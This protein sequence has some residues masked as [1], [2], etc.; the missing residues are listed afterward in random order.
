MQFVIFHI[1]PCLFLNITLRYFLAE[2]S[3]KKQMKT[4]C[5]LGKTNSFVCYLEE[6]LAWQFAFE[7]NWPLF[8]NA[9]TK[10]AFFNHLP[11]CID[12]FNGMNVDKKWTLSCK[13]NLWTLSLKSLNLAC[14]K[15]TQPNI[16]DCYNL[17]LNSGWDYMPLLCLESENR[18]FL[19][20]S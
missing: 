7:I 4:R 3:S 12:I 11:L 6:S 5:T 19:I 15:R 2:D 1:W 14:Q 18:I 20:Q 9:Q 17:M 10:L 8:V 16:I 13:R